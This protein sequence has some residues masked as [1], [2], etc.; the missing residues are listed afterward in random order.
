ME[1]QAPAERIDDP[2]YDL[3]HTRRRT[4]DP[5]FSPQNVAVIGASER[6][7]WGAPSCGT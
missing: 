3:F 4:L 7:A 1:A 5:I 6:G 2:S